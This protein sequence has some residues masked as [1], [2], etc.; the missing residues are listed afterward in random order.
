MTGGVCFKCSRERGEEQWT[1][2][3]HIALK[4]F[5]H[6]QFKER[7]SQQVVTLINVFRSGLFDSSGTSRRMNLTDKARA[8]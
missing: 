1:R 8:V 3:Y 2:T 6:S 4:A 7:P 5:Q